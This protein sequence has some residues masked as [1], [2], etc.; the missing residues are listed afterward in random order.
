MSVRDQ[1]RRAQ[2]AMRRAE[3]TQSRIDSRMQGAVRQVDQ[4]SLRLK[5]LGGESRWAI[6]SR[7]RCLA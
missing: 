3:E 2:E 6:I 7:A 1:E 5:R 4:A